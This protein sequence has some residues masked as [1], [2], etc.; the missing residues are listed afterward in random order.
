M[1]RDDCLPAAKLGFRRLNRRDLAGAQPLLEQVL[2]G[3]D[4]ELADRVRAALKLPQTLRRRESSR[5][6]TSHEAKTLAEKSLKAG[7]MKDALKYLTVAHESDPVD[8]AV[9]LK[10]GWVYNILHQ[11]KQAIQW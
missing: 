5:E 11:D 4:E 8:F 6:R 9:M 10:L 7:Y 2:K 1:A 3:S